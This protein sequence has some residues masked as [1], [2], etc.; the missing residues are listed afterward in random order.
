MHHGRLSGRE[1]PSIPAVDKISLEHVSYLVE[2]G[3]LEQAIET[4]EQGRALL[5]SEMRGLRTSID[6]LNATHPALTSRFSTINQ[7]LETDDIHPAS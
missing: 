6:L 5:W 3:H 7:D 4:L 2:I 1:E